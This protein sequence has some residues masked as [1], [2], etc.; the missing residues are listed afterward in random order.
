MICR[1]TTD[2]RFDGRKLRSLTSLH[3]AFSIDRMEILGGRGVR[4]S[5]HSFRIRSAALP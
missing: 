4:A 2:D 3:A 1:P 5:S